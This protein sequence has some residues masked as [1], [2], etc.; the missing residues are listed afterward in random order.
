MKHFAVIGNPIDQSL[1]PALHN[2]VFKSLNIRA[3][4]NK[5]RTMKEELPYIIQQ[6]KNGKLDGFNV[7][8]PHKESIIDLL[9]EINPRAKSIGA[10]NCVMRSNSK[11]I[12]NNTDWFG[13]TTALKDNEIDLSG[14]EVVV[15]AM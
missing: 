4:Y 3:E 8:I 14:R 5:I 15:L 2:W 13:F 6:I 9:D 7:T 11:I 12:G 10:V 1:S